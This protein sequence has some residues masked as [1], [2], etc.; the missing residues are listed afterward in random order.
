MI[1]IPLYQ[2][3]ASDIREGVDCHFPDTF[4][5]T[6]EK[7]KYFDADV[8][9]SLFYE[10]ISQNRFVEILEFWYFIKIVF[11]YISHFVLGIIRLFQKFVCPLL[12]AQLLFTVFFKDYN[13]C[14]ILSLQRQISSCVSVYVCVT[15]FAKFH[16]IQGSRIP[17]VWVTVEVIMM[18]EMCHMKE[19][20]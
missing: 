4:Q 8:E 7:K 3:H 11:S 16:Q 9:N 14:K 1:L 15:S 10:K 12:K 6:Q 20:L 13:L 19:Q 17:Q 2:I 5:E 18:N